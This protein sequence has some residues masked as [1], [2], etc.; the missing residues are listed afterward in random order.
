MLDSIVA[1]ATHPQRAVWHSEGMATDSTPPSSRGLGALLHTDV[2]HVD[3]G[4]HGGRHLRARVEH[5][6][7]R[8]ALGR[9]W[10][11]AI[12]LGRRRPTAVEVT[13]QAGGMSS[14]GRYDVV[15]PRPADPWPQAARRIAA[16]TLVGWIAVRIARRLR[17]RRIHK[18][19]PE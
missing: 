8:V 4:A 18:G 1:H 19:V 3:L 10:S 14:N 15:V 6:T 2:E 16:I 13:P 11:T 9:R 17:A 5:H 7:L 12:T